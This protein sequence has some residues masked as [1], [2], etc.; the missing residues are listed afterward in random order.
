LRAKKGREAAK[1]L[2]ASLDASTASLMRS[3]DAGNRRIHEA[4]KR[5]LHAVGL[6][7]FNE[8]IQC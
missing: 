4:E 8:M 6:A 3:I 1:D 2:K 7:A 5:R